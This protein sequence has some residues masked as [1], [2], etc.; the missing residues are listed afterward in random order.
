M[1]YAANTFQQISVQAWLYSMS[2]S[3]QLLDSC[4][5]NI[6]QHSGEEK[7]KKTQKEFNC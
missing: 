1:K 2:G 6:L 3:R 4:G 5:R 7:E